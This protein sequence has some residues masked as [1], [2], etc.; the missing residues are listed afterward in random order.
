MFGLFQSG[1]DP[2][3]R[4]QLSK[5]VTF[6]AMGTKISTRL[7]YDPRKS[8]VKSRVYGACGAGAAPAEQD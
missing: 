6:P 2:R 3:W 8:Q 5:K 4:F 1:A 7:R